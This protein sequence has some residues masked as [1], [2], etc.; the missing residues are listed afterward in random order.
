MEG[1]NVAVEG[2]SLPAICSTTSNGLLLSRMSNLGNI[3]ESLAW[4]RKWCSWLELVTNLLSRTRLFWEQS[5]F[6]DVPS[7]TVVACWFWGTQKVIL[8]SFCMI[9]VKFCPDIQVNICTEWQS[10]SSSCSERDILFFS[11]VFGVPWSFSPLLLLS[12]HT[13]WAKIKCQI[14]KHPV[15]QKAISVGFSSQQL[16]LCPWLHSAVKP[17]HSPAF[18]MVRKSFLYQSAHIGMLTFL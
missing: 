8:A 15:E 18:L 7:T 17:M 2:T 14:I 10:I 4:A 9:L 12:L 6:G 11:L 16:S 1:F 13:R 3:W 5:W